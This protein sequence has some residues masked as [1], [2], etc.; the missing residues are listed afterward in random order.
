MRKDEM[1]ERLYSTLAI[2]VRKAYDDTQNVYYSLWVN[3]N[4]KTGFFRG[5]I[6]EYPAAQTE[7]E[8]ILAIRGYGISE[9]YDELFNKLE[10]DEEKEE[11]IVNDTDS[12]F[13]SVNI[14]K[15]MKF[16]RN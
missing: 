11:K 8:Y 3:R 1:I 6:G 10:T 15:V 9:D 13:E 14:D 2:I 12:Y 16:V 5:F 4:G 7:R